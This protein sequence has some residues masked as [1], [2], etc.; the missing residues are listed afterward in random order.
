MLGHSRPCNV[1]MEG[2]SRTGKFT[3]THFHHPT[4]RYHCTTEY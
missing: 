2:Y 3:G 1:T 4:R